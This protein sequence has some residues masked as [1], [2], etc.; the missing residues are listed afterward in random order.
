MIGFLARRLL[1]LAGTLAVA[2]FLV[3]GAVYLA[4]GRPETFLL[5]GRG[6]SPQLLAAIRS[7]Y[8]LDDPFLV[9]YGRWLGD[10][11]T[12]RFGE[13][14]QYRSSVLGLVGSRLPTTVTL[15]G[16]SLVLVLVF[17]IALGWLGAVRGGAADSG[18]LVGTSLALGTPS[19]V[20]GVVM[21]SYLAIRLHWFPD[22][23]SGTGFADLL[24]HLVLPSIALSLYWIG[25]LARVTRTAMLDVLGQEHVTVA[26]GRGV[27][28]R[29]VLRRHVFRNA[30]GP[31]VTT[32][33]LIVTGLVISTVLVEAVFTLNGVGAFLEKSVTVKDFPVVQAVA[34]LIVAVFVL[35]NLVVDLLYP[36]ID[37]RVALGAR[38]GDA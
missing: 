17:G 6:A 25:M 15:I 31:I 3:F 37:P 38:E 24:Y 34:L 36:F 26:R 22:Q 11:L 23:G 32:A 33:G 4:P 14:V 2:S 1:E 7:Q 29:Q 16:M 8:H 13:S 18:V 35:V 5:G 28:E 21:Q 27:P 30:L 10:V 9:Q 20:A 12:G 19:F